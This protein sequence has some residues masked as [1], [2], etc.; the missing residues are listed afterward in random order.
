MLS[1]R[2]WHHE[3]AEEAMRPNPSVGSEHCHESTWSY[4]GKR[5]DFVLGRM[6][7]G[8][9]KMLSMPSLGDKHIVATERQ[10]SLGTG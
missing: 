5:S 10:A 6:M 8:S 9:H 2:C 4:R 7:Q 3:V 1:D